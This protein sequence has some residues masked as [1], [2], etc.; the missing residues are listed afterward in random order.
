[1]KSSRRS[2]HALLS[3]C[4]LLAV[5]SAAP[6]HE[7]HEH[8]FSGKNLSG[9]KWFSVE[10]GTK[11]DEVWSVK[12]GLLVC[13]GEPYGYLYTTKDYKNFHMSLMWRWAPGKEAGNSGVLLR[14]ASEPKW[15]PKCIEAQLKS[16]SAGDVWAFADAEVEG[17]E[18]RFKAVSH[19]LLGDFVG[20][21]AAKNA[22]NKPGEWNQ[23]DITVK[24]G[25]MTLK[26]NGQLVN[27]VTGL[28]AVAGP[29]GLQSEGAE[30]HFKDIVVTPI[31]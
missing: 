1:M 16:E 8:V 29:I 12:D 24:G 27:Q 14:I 4:C 20:V 21:A 13:K 2:V 25:K 18:D 7:G 6:A 30:I 9:W 17:P 23:Y 10:P 31:P 11:M 19:E 26:I 3:T 28:K 5:A 22:E 15:L